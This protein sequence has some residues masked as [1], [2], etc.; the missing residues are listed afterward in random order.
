LRQVH[1]RARSKRKRK[2]VHNWAFPSTPTFLPLPFTRITQ[3]R[4]TWSKTKCVVPDLSETEKQGGEVPEGEM[5]GDENPTHGDASQE[6]MDAMAADSG[7]HDNA[8]VESNVVE[9][10]LEVIDL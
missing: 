1:N 8:A 10:V 5:A 4:S 7:A 2:T 3:E 6:Q 9:E